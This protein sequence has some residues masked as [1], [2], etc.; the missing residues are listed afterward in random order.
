M[1][2][3][4]IYNAIV[5]LVYG[6]VNASP[7][8]VAEVPLIQIWILQKH[9]EIQQ[10][11]NF[12]FNRSRIILEIT[13][14]VDTY[15]L[16]D[17][18]K[19]LINIDP[20]QKIGLPAAQLINDTIV[21]DEEPTADAEAAVNLWEYLETP[22]TW[23]GTFADEMTTYCHWGIIYAVTA[24]I[25]IKREDKNTAGIYMD[26]SAQ[27]LES[28]YADDYGRRQNPGAIF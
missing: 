24:L 17:T 7:V 13:E 27:A 10:N 4:E 22:V 8:P 16:P 3:S 28:V 18:Y 20:D 15:V 12:W 6:D 26:L 9:H 1:T 19:E 23:D 5:N 11:Y 21:F 25:F 2:L 14:G